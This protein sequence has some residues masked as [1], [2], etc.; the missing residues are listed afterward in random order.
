MVPLYATHV[1]K[2]NNFR[3]SFLPTASHKTPSPLFFSILLGLLSRFE[4]TTHCQAKSMAS[5]LHNII[6]A[7]SI[8]KEE[9]TMITHKHLLYNQHSLH[10]LESISRKLAS[11][12]GPSLTDEESLVLNQLRQRESGTPHLRSLTQFFANN[13]VVR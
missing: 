2:I 10:Y 1:G 7:V 9:F 12:F 3:H 4:Y 6:A 5:I 13:F 11:P 8:F